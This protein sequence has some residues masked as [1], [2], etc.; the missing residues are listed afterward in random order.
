[1]GLVHIQTFLGF[2]I[3]GKLVCQLPISRAANNGRSTDNVRSKIGFARS[4]PWMA[5]KFVRSFTLVRKKIRVSSFKYLKVQYY[6]YRCL[7]GQ[8]WDMPKQK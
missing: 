6:Y 3:I 2:I 8:K 4:N 5:G 7:S 1:M